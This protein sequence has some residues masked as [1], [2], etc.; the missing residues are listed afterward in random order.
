VLKDGH[1]LTSVEQKND[2]ISLEKSKHLLWTKF[3][4]PPI[5]SNQVS[6]PRAHHIGGECVDIDRPIIY[7][8]LAESTLGILRLVLMHKYLRIARLPFKVPINNI[9]SDA[10]LRGYLRHISRCK[11]A[12]IRDLFTVWDQVSA[13][14]FSSKT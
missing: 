8:K 12:G 11:P 7:P 14:P 6:R 3:H 2:R 4:A 9:A 10:D 1:S 5:R 13:R